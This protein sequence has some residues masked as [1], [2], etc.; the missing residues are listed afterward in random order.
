MW[1][2]EKRVKMARRF[3]AEVTGWMVV[4]SA[5]L[6]VPR[7]TG[8]EREFSLEQVVWEAHARP[9]VLKFRTQLG[10]WIWSSGQQAELGVKTWC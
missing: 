5:E 2:V 6:Q 8:K 9:Q 10:V 3:L 4:S 1:E 7:G